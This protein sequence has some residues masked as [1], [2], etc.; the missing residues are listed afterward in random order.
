QVRETVTHLF[1][2]GRFEDVRVYASARDAGVALVY[3]LVPI[4]PVDRVTFTGSR[5]AGINIGQLRQ[6]VLERYG[7]SP[8]VGRASGLATVVEDELR[9]HG[10]LHP[11]VKPSTLVRHS[12]DRA[13]LV[14][15]IAAGERARVG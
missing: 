12:P 6:T 7:A 3:E 9:R 13:T 2:F 15:D 1:S 5:G 10:Y 11:V 8:P 14:F 4:H